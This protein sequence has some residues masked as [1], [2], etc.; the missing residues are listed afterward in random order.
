MSLPIKHAS[1]DE[2]TNFSQYQL[3]VDANFYNAGNLAF[4]YVRQIVNFVFS[5]CLFALVRMNQK[6]SI[7]VDACAASSSSFRDRSL[8]P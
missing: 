8:R 6:L 5:Q 7:G 1:A 4:R 3:R 2:S